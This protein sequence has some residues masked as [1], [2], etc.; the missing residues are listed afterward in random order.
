MIELRVEDYCH[1][2]LDFSADVKQPERL[3]AGDEVCATIGTTIVRCE[4]AKRC[5]SIKRYL[6]RRMHT[7]KKPNIE[8]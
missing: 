6:E 3:Y 8:E 2:C 5:A 4:Y 7:E 1:D